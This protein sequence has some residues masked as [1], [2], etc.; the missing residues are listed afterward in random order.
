[1]LEEAED[2]S[3]PRNAGPTAATGPGPANAGM[4]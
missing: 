2:M 4:Y 1:M 3:K